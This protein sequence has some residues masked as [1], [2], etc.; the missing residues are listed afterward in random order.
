MQCRSEWDRMKFGGLTEPIKMARGVAQTCETPS[1]LTA[2]L[3]K[4]WNVCMYKRSLNDVRVSVHGAETKFPTFCWFII[5]SFVLGMQH[6][7]RTKRVFLF[8][9]LDLYTGSQYNKN[10]GVLKNQEHYFIPPIRLNC[11]LLF[12]CVLSFAAAPAVKSLPQ[13]QGE[14]GNLPSAQHAAGKYLW[15]WRTV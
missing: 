13:N 4:I 7:N 11:S 9:N 15:T 3:V 10:F 12:G 2:M 6:K 5:D 8:L 14:F 1:H